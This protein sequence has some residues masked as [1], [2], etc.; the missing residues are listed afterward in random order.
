MIGFGPK[1]YS[2][3]SKPLVDAIEVTVMLLECF[4]Y[5][6]FKGSLVSMSANR[7]NNFKY[8]RY[9]HRQKFYSGPSQNNNDNSFLNRLI[10]FHIIY[11]ISSDDR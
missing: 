9:D 7:L 10:N 1:F 8:I 4:L 6:Y 3:P 5:F 11:Y 2:G